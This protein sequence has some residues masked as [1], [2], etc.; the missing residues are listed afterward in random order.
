MET[1]NE[2]F[3]VFPHEERSAP[4]AVGKTGVAGPLRL[5]RSRRRWS[6]VRF[7]LCE[8]GAIGVVVIGIV[9]DGALRPSPPL[10][11]A[12][13]VGAFFAALVLSWQGLARFAPDL[14]RRWRV[15]RRMF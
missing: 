10:E 8:A 7:L 3:R 5:I 11:L 14:D 1:R 2:L 12:G 13:Q 6:L 15:R 9:L 4:A